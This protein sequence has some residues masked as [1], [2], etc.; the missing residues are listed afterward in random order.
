ML[1]FNTKIESYRLMCMRVLGNQFSAIKTF[2]NNN[3]YAIK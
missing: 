2:L 1:Y 3:F